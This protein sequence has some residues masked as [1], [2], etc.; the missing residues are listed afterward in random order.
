M[1]I[2]TLSNAKFVS[3]LKERKN[4]LFLIGIFFINM[5]GVRKPRKNV[6]FEVKKKD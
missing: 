1:E 5:Q 4:C 2:F 3:K 6:K